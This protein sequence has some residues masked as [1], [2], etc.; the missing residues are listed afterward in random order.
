MTNTIYIDVKGGGG[1]KFGAHDV[2][3][4]FLGNGR[5]RLSI[6]TY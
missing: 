5:M 3:Y 6:V 2:L 4:L 1:S